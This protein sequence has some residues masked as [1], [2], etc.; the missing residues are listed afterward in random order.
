MFVFVQHNKQSY[1]TKNVTHDIL[2]HEQVQI[3][4]AVTSILYMI[5]W[6]THSTKNQLLKVFDRFCFLRRKKC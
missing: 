5:K 4:V 1:S 6:S 2:V 3:S